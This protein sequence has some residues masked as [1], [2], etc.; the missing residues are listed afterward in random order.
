[1]NNKLKLMMFAIG[2]G[3]SAVAAADETCFPS[4]PFCIETTPYCADLRA[5]CDSGD[6]NS[7]LT[8][9]NSYCSI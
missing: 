5:A 6:Y 9:I 4:S 2:M 1:M 7:C 8:W 3:V